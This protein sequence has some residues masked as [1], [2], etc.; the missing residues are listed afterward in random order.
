MA[1]VK[2]AAD[3]SGRKICFIGMS[4]NHYL[5]VGTG[6][7]LQRVG[8]GRNLPT[9]SSGCTPALAVAC[10]LVLHWFHSAVHQP[11]CTAS[12][13]SRHPTALPT[14]SAPQA[15]QREGRAPF[16]P[17]DVI[18]AADLDEYDPNQLLIVTTGSQVRWGR[19]AALERRV[20]CV[21]LEGADC[22]WAQ[23]KAC[24][25]RFPSRPFQAPHACTSRALAPPGG[26]ACAADHGGAR[27][28]PPAQAA[29]QRPR[30]LLS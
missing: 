10:R 28:E 13:C 21:V 9:V 2:K 12:A 25:S 11:S 15:A 27:A 1:A 5:E 8:Q 22:L 24:L 6:G 19:M 3:A 17:K 4:L 23:S 29:A 14:P 7:V 16:D 26:A 18:D 30:P 20:G